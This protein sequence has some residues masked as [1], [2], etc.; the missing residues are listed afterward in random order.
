MKEIKTF[1]EYKNAEFEKLYSAAKSFNIEIT[2][3]MVKESE[4]RLY[5]YFTK[6]IQ[7]LLNKIGQLIGSKDSMFNYEKIISAI[8]YYNDELCMFYTHK[9]G[10]K[11]YF[12]KLYFKNE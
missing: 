1:E 11:T 4:T 6:N 9:R 2:D 7:P 5:N 8:G 12:E 10:R 3:E